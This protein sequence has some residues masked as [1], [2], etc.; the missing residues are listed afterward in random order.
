MLF[1]IAILCPA[2]ISVA[3]IHHRNKQLKFASAKTLIEYMVCLLINVLLTF[4][5]VC[6]LNGTDV[7]VDSFVSMTFFI[8]YV[9]V[10]V[11]LAVV[12]PYIWLILSTYI[13]VDLVIEDYEEDK[14]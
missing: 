8:K 10:A 12:V 7:R 14:N 6:T 2:A 9:A 3:I 5:L 13:R 1:F 4:I 11:V